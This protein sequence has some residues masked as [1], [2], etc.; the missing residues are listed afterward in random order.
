MGNKD[1]EGA[2]KVRE[3]EAAM[4]EATAE[5]IRGGVRLTN[6]RHV[7]ALKGRMRAAYLRAKN[8][9]TEREAAEAAERQREHERA[10]RAERERL[11]LL[12]MEPPSNSIN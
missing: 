5:A 7:E 4:S 1:S 2:K 8:A 3:L 9:I 11:M 12:L 6:E 10:E